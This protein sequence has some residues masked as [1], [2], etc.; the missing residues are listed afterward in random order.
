MRTKSGHTGHSIIV[1]RYDDRV[2]T[3]LRPSH[4]MLRNFFDLSFHKNLIS[5]RKSTLGSI[6]Y[7]IGDIRKSR[8]QVGGGPKS[9]F[10]ICY[11]F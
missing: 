9:L 7:N 5:F 4:S 2:M 1:N 6:S 3:V 10:N 11:I 8:R